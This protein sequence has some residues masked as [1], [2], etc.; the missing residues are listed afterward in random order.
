MYILKKELDDAATLDR[1]LSILLA[2]QSFSLM[3]VLFSTS[4]LITQL[5]TGPTV[6]VLG[7]ALILGLGLVSLVA[8]VVYAICKKRSV[9]RQR[10][11]IF[12]AIRD[13][14]ETIPI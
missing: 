7:F 6:T 3:V 1:K 11:R 12:D 13:R 4:F 5:L 9:S 14:G 2:T 10:S 8:L